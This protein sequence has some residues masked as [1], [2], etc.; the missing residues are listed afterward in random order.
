MKNI[1]AVVVIFMGIAFPMVSS[2]SFAAQYTFIPRLVVNSY[3]TDNVDLTSTDEESDIVTSVIPGF[4]AGVTGRT[5]GIDLT[6]N[7][8]YT[9][10]AN[11]SDRDYW[12]FNADLSSFLDITQHTKITVADNYYLTQDPNPEFITTDVR[13]DQPD[14]IVDP[15]IR[16][17]RDKWWRNSFRARVEQQLD[18]DSSMYVGYQNSILRNDSPQYENNNNNAG[19]AGLTYFFG[20]KWGAQLDG[21]YRRVTYDRSNDYT[22]I[23]SSDFNAWGGTARLIR[24]F[25]RVVEGYAQYAYNQLDY[26]SGTI[27]SSPP[28]SA[29]IVLN[30][31][32]AIHD[33]RVGMEY[34][35]AEDM[36]IAA[37]AGWALK[38]N[39]VTD[40]QDGFVGELAFRKTLPRGGYRLEAG[41]GYDF[42]ANN[43]TNYGFERYYR[44]GFTGDYQFLRR[45]Y[46]DLYGAYRH[47]KYIDTIPERTVDRYTAGVGLTWQPFRWGSARLGYSFRSAY[48]GLETEEYTENRI[49]LTLSLSTELPYRAL[50]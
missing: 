20:P 16:Q 26:T 35:L 4:T 42:G 33:V 36:V 10:Y 38:V 46:G 27:I 18:V 34:N 12:R 13:E 1:K 9:F 2:F 48:S 21:N 24:R 11:N 28:G 14:V 32:Y 17:G 6:F 45:L 40:N 3:Y 7:P 5:A 44:A 31:D 25:S 43:A 15:T 8:G 23:P 19:T 30:E 39:D 50:Y 37:N 49:F 41:A 22:G 29:T 47:S